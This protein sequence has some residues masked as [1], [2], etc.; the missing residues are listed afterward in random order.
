MVGATRYFCSPCVV[1]HCLLTSAFHLAPQNYLGGLT[2]HYLKQRLE[3]LSEDEKSAHHAASAR[4]LRSNNFSASS[5]TCPPDM[6]MIATDSDVLSNPCGGS[7]LQYPLWRSHW[8]SPTLSVHAR[9]AFTDHR[10]QHTTSLEG[11]EDG[12]LRGRVAFT[13]RGVIPFAEKAA[14]AQVCFVRAHTPNGASI[15]PRLL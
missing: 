13:P 1:S 5:D 14:R 3:V 12:G 7:G 11:V 2:A 15:L 4:Q 9:A 8:T 10:V 6:V